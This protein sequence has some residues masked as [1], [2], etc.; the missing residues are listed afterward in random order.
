MPGAS[1]VVLCGE[2]CTVASRAGA[3]CALG[4]R[5]CQSHQ[6][7]VVYCK[8]KK[9]ECVVC[10]SHLSLISNIYIGG[11]ISTSV[12]HFHRHRRLPFVA[13]YRLRVRRS[14]SGVY[15]SIAGRGLYD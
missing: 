11:D 10:L 5:C 3:E 12:C 9:S 4:W 2:L 8:A 1:G 15:P 6:I 13:E 14:R 7:E